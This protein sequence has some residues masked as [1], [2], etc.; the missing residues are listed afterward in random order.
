MS[1]HPISSLHD[2]DLFAE[3]LLPTLKP[4]TIIALSGPLGAGKTTFVQALARAL[5]ITQEPTSPTFSL[6]RTYKTTRP[7]FRTLVHVDA[8]RIENENEVMTLGLE[9]LL[10]E[11][12]VIVCL[13]W[14]EKIPNWI[15]K[16]GASVVPMSIDENHTVRLG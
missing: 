6:V 3:E 7:P 1:T 5:G 13:E 4:G 15:A 2:W 8:Y 9:D 14:P 11:K 16:Q 12:G 10:E